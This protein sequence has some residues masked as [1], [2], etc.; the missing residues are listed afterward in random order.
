[1]IWILLAVFAEIGAGQEVA[2]WFFQ[3]GRSSN[4]VAKTM[5]AYDTNFSDEIYGKEKSGRYV[6]ESR[7][8]KMLDHEYRLIKERLDE[9][10][11]KNTRFFAFSNT[12]ATQTRESTQRSWLARH[13]ISARNWPKSQ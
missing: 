1:M 11:G 12:V 4:T 5:S 9:K 10:R 2:R 13:K 8:I 6:C 7:L 3:A